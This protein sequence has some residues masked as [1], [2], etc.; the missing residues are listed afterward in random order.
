M[1]KMKLAAGRIKRNAV[2]RNSFPT[3]PAKLSVMAIGIRNRDVQYQGLKND[4]RTIPNA[5][6]NLVN[7]L[8]W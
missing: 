7:G 5:K 6:I 1:K 3:L 2:D 4:I 8:S